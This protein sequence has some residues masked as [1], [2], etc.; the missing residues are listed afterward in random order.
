MLKNISNLGLELTKSDQKQ[1]KG[2]GRFNEGF[3]ESCNTS[4]DC[5]QTNTI[6]SICCS[7]ICIYASNIHAFC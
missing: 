1:I 2:S 3:G 4:T 7:G 6:P 5:K